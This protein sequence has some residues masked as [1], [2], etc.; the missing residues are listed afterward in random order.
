MVG[1][2]EKQLC[3]QHCNQF[4]KRLLHPLIFNFSVME[5]VLGKS[6]QI[7]EIY[8]STEF[9][10]RWDQRIPSSIIPTMNSPTCAGWD[11]GKDSF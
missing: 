7:F 5:I 9:R 1:G 6:V 2:G 3:T 8:N 11:Y 10:L 4:Q